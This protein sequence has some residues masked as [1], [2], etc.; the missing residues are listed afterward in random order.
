METISYLWIDE[1]SDC[2]FKFERGSSRFFV[3]AAVF[4]GCEAKEIEITMERLRLELRLA[5]DFEFKF[6]RCKRTFREAFLRTLSERLIRYK[7]VVVDKRE[8]TAPALKF[9]PHQLYCEAVRRLFYDNDPPIVESVLVIDEA[10]AQIHRREFNAVLKQYMSKN[11]VRKI[12]QQRSRNNAMIQIADMIAG[13]IFREY[14]RGDPH[15]HEMIMNKEKIL[16]HL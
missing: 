12:R 8:L 2:G 3:V 11:V 10:S 1:A 6:S 15:Y 5:Q 4:L 16:L 13:S 7:A 14:E 9:H